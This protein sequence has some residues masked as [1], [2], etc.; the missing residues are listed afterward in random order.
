[1]SESEF[2]LPEDKPLSM[3]QKV[4]ISELAA[5]LTIWAWGHNGETGRPMPRSGSKASVFNPKKDG[6]YLAFLIEKAAE[7]GLGGNPNAHSLF[8]HELNYFSGNPR[9]VG[10]GGDPPYPEH[11]PLPGADATD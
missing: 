4:A 1:M 2:D 6:K 11:D 8:A 9:L 3:G 10:L 7:A 5:T